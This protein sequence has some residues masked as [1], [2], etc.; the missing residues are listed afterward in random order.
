MYILSGHL[1]VLILT[2]SDEKSCSRVRK[3]ILIHGQIP[4]STLSL[5]ILEFIFHQ[6]TSK[7]HFHLKN[8]KESTRAGVFA[9]TEVQMIL[10][11]HGKKMLVCLSRVLTLAIETQRV[12]LF[13]LWVVLSVQQDWSRC[14][15]KVSSLGDLNSVR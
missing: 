7:N 4:G 8:R 10:V 13:W 9:M 6:H 12:E 14:H 3:N 1:V 5:R 15:S 2:L 11:G